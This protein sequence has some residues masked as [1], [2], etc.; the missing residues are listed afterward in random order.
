MQVLQ[1]TPN[2]A[3]MPSNKTDTLVQKDA[4]LMTAGDT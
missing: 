2:A 4:R 3:R 1:E